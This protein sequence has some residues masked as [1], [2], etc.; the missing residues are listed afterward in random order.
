[1]S[2]FER[3]DASGRVEILNIETMLAGI[4]ALNCAHQ[5]KQFVGTRFSTER[6]DYDVEHYARLLRETF[7]IRLVR[8]FAPADFEAVFAD[9]GQMSL[10]TESVE[11]IR[12]ILSRERE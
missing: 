8:A 10:F 9:P 12:T 11:T 1:M 3:G 6:R 4:N 2:N 7:A 5:L